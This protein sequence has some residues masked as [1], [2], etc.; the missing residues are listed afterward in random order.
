MSV[1]T[2]AELAAAVE[3]RTPQQLSRMLLKFP[4]LK[5]RR[6]Q[7]TQ[8]FS[9]VR[10][11]DLS[12]HELQSLK[13]L[14]LL[15]RLTLLKCANNKLSNKGMKAVG[16]LTELAVLNAMH[17]SLTRVPKALTPLSRLKVIGHTDYHWPAPA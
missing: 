12:G 11:L 4:Q 6:V 15:P 9:D 2:D 3:G 17:N 10:K 13:G 5:I 1:L 7:L 16:T 8:E 14:G